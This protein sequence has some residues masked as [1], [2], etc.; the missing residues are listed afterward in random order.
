MSE[1]VIEQGVTLKSNNF[2]QKPI[3]ARSITM[4]FMSAF[5]NSL[6]H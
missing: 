4:T 5:I 2:I 6:I 1:L 3:F